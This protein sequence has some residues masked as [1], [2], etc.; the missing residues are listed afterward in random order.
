[1]ERWF[2]LC[3]PMLRPSSVHPCGFSPRCPGSKRRLSCPAQS[4]LRGVKVGLK[5]KALQEPTTPGACSAFKA[6]TV[7]TS[8]LR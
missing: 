7:R 1:M 3:T 6:T 2:R 4:I 5:K 8:R